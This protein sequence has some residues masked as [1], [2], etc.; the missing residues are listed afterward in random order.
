M[1]VH[2]LGYERWNGTLQKRTFRWLPMVRYHVNLILKRKVI[3]LILLI[4]IVPAI[5]FSG[6]IY[7]SSEG[8][9]EGTQIEQIAAGAQV[10]GQETENPVDFVA[11][12]FFRREA[13]SNKP[14]TMKEKYWFVTT[15]GLFLLLLWPQSFIV[16]LV[17]SAVGASLIAQDVRSNALEIYLTKPITPL[18]YVLG[19]LSV[20]TVFIMLTT[21]LPVMIVF[22]VAAASWQGFFSVTWTIIPKLFAICL[23][24]SVVNGV[25][26]LGLSSLAKSGRYAT[27]IWFAIGFIS[28]VSSEFLRLFTGE[29]LWNFVS[30]RNNFLYL[31]AKFLDVDLSRLP[32]VQEVEASVLVP[33]IVL[34][35][36]VFFSFMI[37]RKTIRAVEAS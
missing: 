22:G 16:M 5:V 33:I 37:M 32:G 29:P 3:W 6:V 13:G 8:A 24:A 18:D 4:S 7:I 9:R 30:Y 28:S 25:V 15:H 21:F 14:L 20:V 36:L 27:V 17:A 35:G 10:L 19:K 34:S 26:I 2:D 12:R 11:T 1:A 23:V 31:F